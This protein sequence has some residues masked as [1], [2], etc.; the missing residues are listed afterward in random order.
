MNV[1]LKIS[2]LEDCSD[3]IPT[4]KND[5]DSGFDMKSKIDTILHP[6][7]V[8]VVPCGF[9]MS[10]SKGFEGQVRPRSGL[11]AK[12]GVTVLNAPGTIDSSYRGEVCSI[13]INH[14]RQPYTIH[15]GDRISQL[16]IAELPSVEVE[17]VTDDHL[18]ETER[19]SKGFGSSGVG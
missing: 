14:G 3:L 17:I 7:Q 12:H 5:E 6:G 15:R 10:V 19:G 4:R 9:K 16:V 2:M 13:L 1:T 11:A 18:G 8:Q